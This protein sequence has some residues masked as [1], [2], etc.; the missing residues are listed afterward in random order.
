M[1]PAASEISATAVPLVS[2]VAWL[3]VL[4]VNID[5]NNRLGEP[6]PMAL[7]RPLTAPAFTAAC[8]SAGVFVGF[9][10]CFCVV[11][12]VVCGVVLVVLFFLVCAVAPVYH[13]EVKLT[14]GFLCSLLL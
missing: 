11:V 6:V 4:L 13:A 7:S 12:F 1:P 8:T 3:A 5:C 2:A 10:V 14:P 9:C